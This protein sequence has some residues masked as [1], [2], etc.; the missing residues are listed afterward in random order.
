MLEAGG[1]RRRHATRR[2]QSS[3]RFI[4]CFCAA[5]GA[6]VDEA[7]AFELSQEPY[8]PKRDVDEPSLIAVPGKRRAHSARD[9]ELLA[10]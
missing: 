2:A 9:V 8:R 7:L 3:L 1:Q 5:G 4:D 6:H 10:F